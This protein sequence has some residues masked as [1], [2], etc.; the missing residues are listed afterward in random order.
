MIVVGRGSE[1]KTSCG[2]S[3]LE[4]DSSRCALGASSRW[5]DRRA[6]PKEVSRSKA[7]R[8]MKPRSAKRTLM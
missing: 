5:L 4:W 6:V 3:E 1:T 8:S 7:S 2:P